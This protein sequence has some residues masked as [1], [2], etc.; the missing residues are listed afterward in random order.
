MTTTFDARKFVDD[1]VAS[2]N[3]KNP[4][5][6][7]A[8]YADDAEL[9]DPTMPRPMR[10]KDAIR[11]N[12]EKWST[13]FS[14]IT[15]TVRDLVQSGDKVALY[16]EAK[17]RNTGELEL[18]PGERIP[19]TNKMV[20][21][22]IAEFLTISPQGKITKDHT[23]FDSLGMMVQLGLAPGPQAA[24]KPTGSSKVTTSR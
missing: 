7:L 15:F 8:H 18:G 21:M 13:A 19:P 14:E 3:S 2:N 12:F 11:A 22:P 20:T 6:L 5:K 16:A 23:V 24:G 17:G 9:S 1:F 10:G 4:E